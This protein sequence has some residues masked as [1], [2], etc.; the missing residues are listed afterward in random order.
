[1]YPNAYMVIRNKSKY[2]FGERK[3]KYLNRKVN[4]FVYNRTIDIQGHL[5]RLQSE[6]IEE[7]KSFK[8]S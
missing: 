4:P 3:L 8:N 2:V 7:Q 1:M 5:N 6:C